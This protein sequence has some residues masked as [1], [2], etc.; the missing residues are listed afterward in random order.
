M[1]SLPPAIHVV[2]SGDTLYGIA[3]EV[4]GN[5]YKW[6]TIWHANPGISNPNR[7]YPGEQILV[8]KH[9]AT[10]AANVTRNDRD[11]DSDDGIYSPRHARNSLAKASNQGGSNLSGTLSCSGLESLWIANG[12]SPS[13]A[14]I[15]AEI[16]KAESGG[17][18]YA[19]GAAGERGY[20]Q[21][22]PIH[23]SLS[24]YDP[25]GNAKAAI[26]LSNDGANWSAWTTYTGGLYRGQC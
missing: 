17:S 19:T 15:A 11:N 10:L 1:L 8:P 13:A 3:Q 7:I 23:G 26:F 2:V 20:W 4:Y 22:H 21:I 18:Q 24:T 14:F 12:G 25:N 16:A 5:G 9:A 6:P